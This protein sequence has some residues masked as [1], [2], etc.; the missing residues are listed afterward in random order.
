MALSTDAT[1]TAPTSAVAIGPSCCS[2]ATL[3]QLLPSTC[4]AVLHSLWQNVGCPG[5]LMPQQPHHC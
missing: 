4:L 3:P 5:A 1:A 2:C